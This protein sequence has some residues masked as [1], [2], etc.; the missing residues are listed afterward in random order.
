MVELQFFADINFK[1]FLD[2]VEQYMGEGFGKVNKGRRTFQ[3]S[4][5]LYLSNEGTLAELVN[6]YGGRVQ[7]CKSA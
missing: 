3:L 6:D 7:H 1:N 4:G 2:E 5:D